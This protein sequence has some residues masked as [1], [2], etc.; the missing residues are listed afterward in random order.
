MLP[1]GG[2]QPGEAIR[3]INALRAIVGKRASTA[4]RH[5]RF[6]EIALLG[7]V[8]RVWSFGMRG[9]IDER[10]KRGPRVRKG[11][12]IEDRNRILSGELDGA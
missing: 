12:R 6:S 10:S 9:A 8:L 7:I 5:G 11:E 3:L 2:C 4:R 1:V